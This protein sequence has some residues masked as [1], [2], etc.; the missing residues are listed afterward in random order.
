MATST[1]RQRKAIG[2]A[3][4]TSI[5]FASV[6]VGLMV[7]SG[8]ASADVTMGD[9]AIDD[10]NSTVG[11]DVSEVTLA[12]T[13]GYAQ[14]VP[15]ATRRIVR[16]SVGPSE[17]ELETLA[18]RQ[19]RD[20]S[21]T[22]SGEVELSGDLISDGPFTTDDFDPALASSTS[23]TVVVQAQIEVH[24]E[25]GDPVTHMLTDT[26]TVTLSDDAEL[27]VDLGGSGSFEVE[28]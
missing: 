15:D 4:A 17:D 20:P 25:N 27:T 18:F 10:H 21:G 6:G 2:I 7:A 26:A 3:L 13:L 22:A 11:G 28:T 8:G 19:E 14:D 1:H 23:T 24:R 9:L 12:T 16:V 5:L